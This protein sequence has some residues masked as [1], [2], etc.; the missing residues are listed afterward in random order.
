MFVADFSL[1]SVFN[2]IDPKRPLVA[3]GLVE[4]L[5]C[6]VLKLTVPIFGVTF[7]DRNELARWLRKEKPLEVRHFHEIKEEIVHASY[8]HCVVCD[9]RRRN[10]RH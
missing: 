3:S 6:F 4:P 5:Q 1:K 10:G 8:H 7:D 2:S 9:C